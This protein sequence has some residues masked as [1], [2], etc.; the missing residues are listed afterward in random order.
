M[1]ILNWTSP[2]LNDLRSID[3]WLSERAS[4]E[5]AVRTLTF[6]RDR[7]HFL[8]NFPHGGRPEAG[9]LRVLRVSETP[10]LILYRLDGD[11]VYVLRIRHE[12]ED[13][14]VEP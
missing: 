14:R 3:A 8:R 9:G 2:A 7:A 11:C 10:W 4:P 5:I 13:W 6:I 1:P 12:R